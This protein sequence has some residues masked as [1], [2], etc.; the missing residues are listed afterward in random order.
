[1]HPC[2]SG[3]LYLEATDDEEGEDSIIIM[4]A[5]SAECATSLWKTG[6]GPRFKFKGEA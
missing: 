5:C 3:W 4:L 2:P 6:P 1:M